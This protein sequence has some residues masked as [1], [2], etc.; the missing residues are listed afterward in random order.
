ME[1]KSAKFDGL[2]TAEKGK[3]SI[4]LTKSLT[5]GL[6]HFDEDLYENGT[7]R[8]LSPRRSK[9]AAA[10]VKGLSQWLFRKDSV[11]LY[12][13]ASHGYTVSF[14][15]DICPEGIIFAI[16]SA[17]RVVRDLIFVCEQRR[18]IA[19][20]LADANKPETYQERIAQ[21]DILYQD[22]AQKNQVE[23]FLKNM[24]L[25]RPGGFGML[26][27]KARSVDITKKPELIFREARAEL[28]KHT[29]V[30]DYRILHPFEKDHAFF[31]CK[32]K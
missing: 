12:L 15:S 8:E 10:V 32:K 22:V 23:I 16:D 31:L 7:Y 27:L 14:L 29:I 3:R 17:P 28:E 4:L 2:F 5:P 11:I 19:P 1:I 13:G 25:V 18:N 21:P 26:A 24:Q 30:A 9:L 6:R 20:I